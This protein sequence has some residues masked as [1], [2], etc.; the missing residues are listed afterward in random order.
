MGDTINNRGTEAQGPEF[1]KFAWLRILAALVL[2]AALLWAISWLSG[3]LGGGSGPAAGPE[4]AAEES[5]ESTEPSA[6]DSGE[7]GGTEAHPAKE[8]AAD[9]GHTAGGHETAEHPADSAEHGEDS[10][11][12]G[13]AHHAPPG[14]DPSSYETKGAY[15]VDAL[16]YPINYELNERF[17]GWRPNDILNITDNVNEMQR[18]TLELTRRA[19]VALTE[20]ISRPG[21]ASALNPHLENAMNAFM[22]GSDSYW[23]PS[24]ESKY[25]EAIGELKKYRQQLRK[26][27]AF[28]FTR[29]DSLIPLLQSFEELLGSCDENLVKQKEDDGEPVS[30]F[31][32]DNYF[33][34]AKGVAHAMV[35]ILHA[36]GDEFAQL[37]EV[38][39]AADILHH[40]TESAHHAAAMDPWLFVTDG[41]LNGILANHR[42]NMAAHISHAR[43]YIGVL[44]KT[45]ST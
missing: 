27:Q 17:W 39:G 24:A 34:Y 36:V 44:V 33:Y 16:I 23:M 19:T 42:A 9:S 5:A 22:I 40:A 25:N 26:G 6:H 20:K 28:F 38:R 1:I 3:T 11:E 4:K 31:Q 30:S 14:P 35:P 37:M 8:E 18:G 43:Y 12:H 41:D 45:L 10:G 7:T 21:S 15:F 29:S 32:A 2:A 13:G